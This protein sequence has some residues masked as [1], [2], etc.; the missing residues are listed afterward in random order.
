MDT[1]AEDQRI[2]ARAKILLRLAQQNDIDLWA[3]TDRTRQIVRFQGRAA[4]VRDYLD[5]CTST[6][7]MVYN[8]MFPRNRQPV[9]LPDLMNKFKN[10]HQIHDFVKAQLMAGARFALI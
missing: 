1:A 2:D 10:V 8:A 7:A 3:D 5:F 6:L 9:N 4:Q